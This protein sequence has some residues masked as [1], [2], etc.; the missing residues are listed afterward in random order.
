MNG[1]YHPRYDVT[2]KPPINGAINGPEK[3]IMENTVI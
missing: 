3:T 1:T 2:M